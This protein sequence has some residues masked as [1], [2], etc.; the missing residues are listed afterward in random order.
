MF[1]LR[2]DRLF[3]MV[4][5][6]RREEEDQDQPRD[7]D[8]A[9]DRQVAHYAATS[10]AIGRRSKSLDAAIVF[11]VVPLPSAAIAVPVNTSTKSV[12]ASSGSCTCVSSQTAPSGG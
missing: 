4:R 8:S 5:N 11:I 10:S 12:G 6:V 3:E 7:E 2:I 1:G 9:D